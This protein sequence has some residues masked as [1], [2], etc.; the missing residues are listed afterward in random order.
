VYCWGDNSSGQLGDNTTTARPTPVQAIA[1]AGVTFAQ[2]D[3][4]YSYT[5]AVT[6]AGAAYCWGNNFSGQ[7][8][9]NTTVGKPV[10]TA[11]QGTLQFAIVSSGGDHTCGVTTTGV[12]Y[13]WGANGN[14]QL[15]DNTTQNRLTPTA[16]AGGLILSVPAAGL[17]HSCAVATPSAV[18]YCWGYNASGQLGDGTTTP[19]LQPTL[20]AQ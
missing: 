15:G 13:C 14:G 4:G 19:R 12:G 5:C 16:I 7:L 20:V 9:D 6:P 10:P 3:A 1:P 18:V 8:G 11:V 2:V 17:S